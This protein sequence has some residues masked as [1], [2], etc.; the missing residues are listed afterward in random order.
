MATAI[1]VALTQPV[2]I[3]IAIFEVLGLGFALPYVLISLLPGLQ[4]RLPKPGAWMET[5]QQFL[6]FPMYMAAAWLVWVLTQQTG[7]AGL[8]A[9]LAGLI[10][11]GFAAWLYRKSQFG[12]GVWRRLGTLTALAVLGFAL[13][14]AQIPTTLS[15]TAATATTSPTATTD[16]KEIPWEPYSM[17]RLSELRQMG[18]PV[19][20]DFTADWCITCL[21]NKRV[22]LSQPEVIAAFATQEVAYLKADWTNRDRSITT[23]LESFGR[24]GVPLY[25]FYPDNE[26]TTPILLPQILSVAEVKRVISGL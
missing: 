24:S 16:T 26:A 22:T 13:T 10:C 20:V 25:V 23:A 14:L 1:G 7:T 5:L 8:A 2:G 3:A 6:A 12:A 19:F 15:T 4:R 21:V 9:V 17:E 18:K 11:L